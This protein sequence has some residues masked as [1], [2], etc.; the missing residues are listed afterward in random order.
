MIESLSS[1]RIIASDLL[2]KACWV[3]MDKTGRVVAMGT[4]TYALVPGN[5]SDVVDVIVSRDLDEAIWYGEM[6]AAKRRGPEGQCMSPSE[7]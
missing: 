3:G 6:L 1:I 2:P 7:T 5:P 4:P